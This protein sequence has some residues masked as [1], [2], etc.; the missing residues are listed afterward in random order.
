[1]TFDAIDWERWTPNEEA[2]LLFVVRDDRI[3]LIHKKRG[4]GSG[5]VNGPG[6]RL[7]DGEPAA[8]G[9]VREFREELRATPSGVEKRGEVLFQMTDGTAI[10]IHVFLATG[11]EGEPQETEEA[12]PFWAAVDAI[13]YDR[14]WADDR[15][16]MPA[17][18]AGRRFALRSLF[19][20]EMLL[21]HQ[22][23]TDGDGQRPRCVGDE[24]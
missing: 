4:L 5:K 1:M 16:W 18:L 10:R 17:M 22:L 2:T 20:G 6:G 14:M 23:L 19:D 9:A 21:G 3:L 8:D 24:S 7:T 13:P 12:A 15:H 11:L